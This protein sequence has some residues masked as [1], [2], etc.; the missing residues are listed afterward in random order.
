MAK[1]PKKTAGADKILVCR[2]D[3]CMACRSCEL[4]CAMV[5]AKSKDVHEAVLEHPRPQRRVTV[6]AVGSRGLPL[7]CRQCEDG[8]CQLVCPTGAIHRDEKT[9][10]VRVDES[11]CIGCKLCT[12]MCPLGVLKIGERTRATIK[13]DLCIERQAEGLEPACVTACPTHALLLVPRQ[14]AADEKTRAAS[15]SVV[16]EL[17]GGGEAEKRMAAKVRRPKAARLKG[18]AGRRVAVIGSNA[19]GAMAA[20]N[21]AESGAKV[22]LI[23][24]DP[25]S[26]RRPAIPALIA[27]NIEDIAAAQIFTPEEFRK[28]GIEILAP[29]TA[30]GLDAAR[31]TIAVRTADGRPREIAYDAAVLATG[32]TA[33][34]PK[35]RGADKKGVCTF[36]TAEG[37]AQIV[38]YAADAGAAVV[39]GASFVALEVAQAL[40]EKGLK[41][42]F[43]VRSRILRRL[44]EPDLSEYLEERFAERGLTMLTGESISEIGGGDRAEYVVHAGKKVPCGLVVLGAGVQPN[45]KLAQAA[46]IRLAESGAIAVDSRMRTSAPDVYAAGDCAEARD[47][48]TGRFVYSA[49]GSTGALAGALAGINAAGGDA[50]TDGFLRAQADQILG[51][52]IYS[53]GHTT[54]TAEEIGLEV[55]VHDLPPPP[56]AERPH[57]QAR[58]KLLTDTQDRIVGGQAVALRHGSQYAWQLY[59]AVLLG[60]KREAF[61][62]RWM[63]PRRRA[64]RLAEQKGW[65]D[66]VV[67][68]SPCGA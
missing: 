35:I 45:V 62:K 6:E 52:Q 46:G 12:L 64:A 68:Q 36:T 51:L 14:E 8:L 3:R 43:N 34:R 63:A 37:A 7:Q 40:M 39:V 23:T 49:V 18:A 13:C 38:R 2:I 44:V 57:E 27:G 24:A 33:S 41:V 17:T 66:L 20:I 42:Y 22:T 55:K 10:I 58:A 21:A 53:I 67:V 31:K 29:A 28:R 48:S 1:K 15:V 30:T 5:H 4:A 25:V 60:E 32:G 26:Y 61:L 19:A 50:Q 16:A 9:G 65:G 11:L 47:L 56:E 54:T 59:A